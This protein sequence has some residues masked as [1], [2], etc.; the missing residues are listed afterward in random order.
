MILLLS[1]F[2]KFFFFCPELDKDKAI[3]NE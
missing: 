1:Y 2:Q 3:F